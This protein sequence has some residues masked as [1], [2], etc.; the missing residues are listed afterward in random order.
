MQL[1][2]DAAPELRCVLSPG[3]D[4]GAADREL[5]QVGQHGLTRADAVVH[6]A[7]PENSWPSRIGVA[8]MRC[9]R[10]DDDVVELLRLRVEHL[11][12]VR[13]RRQQFALDPKHRRDV[14]RVNW[15]TSLL[16]WPKF[17]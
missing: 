11:P 6:P 13:E 5:A 12:E 4:R 1:A 8:S 14:Q 9:V 15:I 2:R 10:P 3:A 17:T 16:L 7:G